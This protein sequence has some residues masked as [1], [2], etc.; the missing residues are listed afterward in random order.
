MGGILMWLGALIA[1]G[2]ALAFAAMGLLALWGAARATREQLVPG[3]RTDRPG[4][5]ERALTLA[6]VWVPALVIAGF[7][8][9]AAAWIA[10]VAL[11]A[12]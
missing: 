5:L 9:Y 8:V 7:G 11:A 12:L 4:A 10:N 6:A 1:L 3:F 2:A